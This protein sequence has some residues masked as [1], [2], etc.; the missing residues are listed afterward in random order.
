MFWHTIIQRLPNMFIDRRTRNKMCCDR[1]KCVLTQD[2][3]LRLFH[4]HDEK[5]SYYELC[6]DCSRLYDEQYLKFRENF[7]KYSPLHRNVCC[8]CGVALINLEKVIKHP[9][10]NF[11]YLCG[12]CNYQ[13][14]EDVKAFKVS[15]IKIKQDY[16]RDVLKKDV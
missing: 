1:C 13:F 14:E 12:S 10:D 7:V 15:Y 9:Y 2:G 5:G 3:N 8:I 11:K 6:N 4:G 16:F